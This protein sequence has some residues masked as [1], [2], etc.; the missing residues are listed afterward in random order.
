[1][2]WHN[3]TYMCIMQLLRYICQK[4]SPSIIQE[5][6]LPGD[7]NRISRQFRVEVIYED[8]RR[9][10]IQAESSPPLSQSIAVNDPGMCRS[11][12]CLTICFEVSFRYM[13]LYVCEDLNLIWECLLQS[14]ALKIRRQTTFITD[15]T[16]LCD[17]CF[18]LCF[19]NQTL[20]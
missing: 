3:I 7:V 20:V 12:K 15:T 19:F 1:M 14:V 10:F 13:Y 9:H 5:S 4:F 8:G 11:H 17:S 2:A 18:L 6:I 16:T